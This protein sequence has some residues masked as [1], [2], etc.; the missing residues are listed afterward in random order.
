MSAMTRHA[1]YIEFRPF[2]RVGGEGHLCRILNANLRR[3]GSGNYSSQPEQ[4]HGPK[5]K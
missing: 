2:P 5:S 1:E 4:D 3:G